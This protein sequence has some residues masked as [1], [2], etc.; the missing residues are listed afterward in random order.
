MH[1]K[2]SIKKKSYTNYTSS[3]QRRKIINIILS[4]PGSP[5]LKEIQT[6]TS[7]SATGAQYVRA[8]IL[9]KE[10]IINEA[11]AINVANEVITKYG[12]DSEGRST[13]I[14]D[15]TKAFAKSLTKETSNTPLP[16]I[17][18]NDQYIANTISKL[19]S[20]K[21]NIEKELN[22]LRQIEIAN[23]MLCEY[24]LDSE[25]RINIINLISNLAKELAKS[26]EKE[27][28]NTPNLTTINNEQDIINQIRNYEQKIKPYNIKLECLY[29][30][31]KNHKINTELYQMYLES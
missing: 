11:T 18:N 5:S 23:K 26:L 25:R 6:A 10:L 4:L 28:L 15:L 24:G 21:N 14:K 17:L 27:T 12:I 29:Q 8:V 3:T 9:R 16:I 2:K 19:E 1:K 20:E 13:F 30:I 31:S 22:F 7:L